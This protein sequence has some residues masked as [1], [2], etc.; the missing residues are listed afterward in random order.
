[1]DEKTSGAESSFLL[2]ARFHR[3]GS[4]KTCLLHNGNQE[5]DAEGC[6]EAGRLGRVW[7][8]FEEGE[9]I[10]GYEKGA[11]KRSGRL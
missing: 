1:M 5:I 11:R 2:S 9:G 8:V 10:V 6:V 7:I 3:I 4:Q